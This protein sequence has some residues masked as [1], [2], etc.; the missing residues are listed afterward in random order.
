MKVSL[1]SIRGL[2]ARYKCSD[3]IAPAG[4]DALVEKIGSQLGA[5]EAVVDIGKKY[6]GAVI[7]TIVDCQKLEDSDHLSVCKIDDKGVVQNVERDENGHVQ[8]V[9]GAPNVVKDLTVIWLPPGTTVPETADKEPFVLEAREIRGQKSNGMLASSRELALGDNHDGILEVKDGAAAGTM[10]AEQYNLVGDYSIDIENKMFTHRP[11]CFGFL[12]ISRELAGIQGMQFK[13][14]DWYQPGPVFPDVE[15]EQL[16]VAVRNEIP[17]LA[18]RFSVITMSGV[19]IKP[20]PLWLQVELA[21]VGLRSVNNIVDYTNFFM[22][23]TGQPLHA[24]DYDKV[25]ALSDG[26]AATIVIR[27]P[28]PGEKIQLLNGRE[29]EPRAEAIM[30]ATDK[31]VIGIGGVMGGSET[32]VDE[33]TKNIIIEVANFDMYSIRR[34]SMEHGIFTDAVTRF[35]KGQSP[36]QNLAVLARIVAEIRGSEAGKVAS[37]V[38]DNNHLPAEV[39][40]RQSLFPPITVTAGFIN[41][42]LGLSLSSQEMAALL[43]NVE[44]AVD[45]TDESLT[46]RAPFWRTDIELRE[47]LVEEVGRLYGFDKLPL[48][49]PQRDLTPAVED[50]LMELKNR[51]RAALAKAGANEV[52]T[53]SFVH[54]KLFDAVTQDREQAFKVSNALSPGLQ[55][56]RLHALPSLLDKVHLNI[57]AGYEEFALF[58]LNKG[59]NLLHK[60]DDNGVP[61]EIEF[62]DFVYTSNKKQ[63]GAA[64]YRARRHLDALAKELGLELEYKPISEDPHV[65]VSDPY[66]YTRS[67]FVSVR[68]GDFLGMVGELKPSVLKS[69][70]LPAQTAVFTIG[71]LQLQASL[72]KQPP[73]YRPLPKFPKLQQDICLKVGQA[74]AYQELYDFV[75]D[76]V[77]TVKPEH[78]IATLTPVDIYQRDDDQEHKQIT[79]RLSLAS[80]NKTLTDTEVTALLDKLAAAAHEAFGAERI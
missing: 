76:T 22:L 67:A 73:A 14:P 12:G 45:M 6:E 20:S 26:D 66:D 71:P 7:V 34:T 35:N 17:S 8:V 18:P 61:T 70:K 37:Q 65:P 44:F 33:T 24:Y 74:M 46:V 13:S 41:A 40:S 10:F 27:N 23:K 50:P 21:K 77:N 43:T 9:C 28:K 38:V 63:P 79:F 15:G 75:H 64:F 68:G 54:G 29:V 4:I 32:E 16:P 47:D 59:H 62:L 55:Y 53:Y 78:A 56:F 31:K 39:M 3:D 57:K 72:L 80:Y 51:I 11:D 69:L 1:N 49:L 52:L 25:A 19:K 2:N 58:E 30:I 60:D 5:V 42:R 48:K 36:L